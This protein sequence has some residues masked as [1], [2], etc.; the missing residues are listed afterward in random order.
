MRR[1][2]EQIVERVLAAA[3]AAGADS[4]DAL[5]V[6]YQSLEAAVREGITENIERA[7][8]EDLGLR[9]F[10]GELQAIVSMSAFDDDTLAKAAERAVAMAKA[11]PPD[12]FAGLADPALLADDMPSLD[13]ADGAS[14][15]EKQLLKLALDCEAAALAVDG[16]TK[17]AGAG[18]SGGRR[19][20]VLGSSA[21][22]LKS[23][24]RTGYGFS[25]AAVAGGGV[26]MERDYAYSSAVHF[27]DLKPPQD[28][29]R[30]A[31]ERAIKRL[32]PRKVASQSVAVVFDPR[33]AGGLVAHLAG[34]IS[35]PAIARGTS[36]L[37]DMLG[38]AVFGP[39]IVIVDDPLIKRG[40]G[41]R[42]FDAEGVRT[43]RREFVRDGVLTT[44]MLDHRSARQ[45]GLTSTGNA[46]RGTSSPP[47]PSS[48]NLYMAK[49]TASPEALMADIKSGLY[50]TELM[51][52]GVNGVTGDYSRGA[53]GFWIE[54]GTLSYPVSEITI[55]GNLKDMYRRLTPADDLEF[56]STINAPTVR[57]EDMTVAG[58]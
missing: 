43:A 40:L 23:Y 58:A 14:P 12:P 10:V 55:A 5:F 7:E 45:L 51:G 41:S 27:A 4:A 3:R 6:G 21:G 25:V 16:I 35:G 19:R 26:E 9:V 49:G 34:A 8:G 24:E 1:G 17:S 11:A 36:F 2:S 15:D 37:K 54:N 47:S 18:A 39:G 28:V 50:V 44:W 33:V 56:K 31:G 30:E 53:T 48:S 42:P 29:G 20:V 57:I 32:K 52:S 46:G 22:F 38:K 13:L